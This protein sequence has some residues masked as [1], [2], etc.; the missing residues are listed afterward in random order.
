M[1]FKGCQLPLLCGLKWTRRKRFIVKVA[2]GYSIRWHWHPDII[3]AVGGIML[4]SEVRWQ[5]GK[6]VDV[7]ISGDSLF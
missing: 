1:K 4:V 2:C 5:V 3:R 7:G 6:G